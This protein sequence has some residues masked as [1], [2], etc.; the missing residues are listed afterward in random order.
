VSALRFTAL[1]H[2]I[3]ALVAFVC[4]AG[5]PQS[6]LGASPASDVAPSQSAGTDIWVVST[7]RLPDLC[8]LPKNVSFDVERLVPGKSSQC[9]RWL[10]S[11]LVSLLD[12][13]TQPLLIFIHGNRYDPA[14]AKSQGLLLARRAQACCPAGPQVRTVIFSWPSSQ[15]GILLQDS[16]KKYQRSMTDGHYL[17]WLLGQLEPERPLA[18]VGYSYG[19]LISL[20]AIDNLIKA[21]QAGRT[22]LQSL[23]N[24][25]G[26]L[27]L[28]LVAAAVRQDALAPRGQ[29]RRVLGSIDRLTLL[30]NTSD[31]PLGFF[32][33]IDRSLSTEALGHEN[34]PARWVPS[35][36][37]FVQFDAASIVGKSHRF[38]PYIDSPSLRQRLVT[39]ALDG[40]TGD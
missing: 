27:N 7:R 32:E 15:D 5:V 17:G 38:P 11:D 30:N 19:A 34:M 12:D 16:R 29:Y 24:R 2:W 4:L 8:S 10:R 18:I 39:G 1:C 23:I 36:V 9:S 21:E 26:R 14:S 3:I 13:P 35:D 22:E 28:V 40:L 33:Y 20:E 37:E 6:E 31:K 25:P